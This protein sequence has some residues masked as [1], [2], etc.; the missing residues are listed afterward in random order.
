MDKTTPIENPKTKVEVMANIIHDSINAISSNR[1][2]QE[3]CL[4]CRECCEYVEIPT[5]MLSM[6]VV[7]YWY[8]RGEQFYIN[9]ASGVFNIRLFKPC[10]HL[11][12]KGC[13]I[14]DN[15]PDICRRFVCSYGD[16]RIKQ[17][18]ENVCADT[19]E[20]IRKSIENWKE[21][22][23]NDLQQS[24]SDEDAGVPDGSTPV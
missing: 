1:E 10:Q 14:Y 12:E 18:K 8:V 5:T 23:N 15:R 6:E 11:T 13:A 3:K 24:K 4:A 20:H 22:K 17:G 21:S 16:D 19:M 7:E 9:P 2:Q